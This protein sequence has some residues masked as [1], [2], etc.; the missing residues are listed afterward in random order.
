MRAKAGYAKGGRTDAAN[1]DKGTVLTLRA[2]KADIDA[3]AGGKLDAEGFKA[4]V[5]TT[6]YAGSGT[7]TTSINSWIQESTGRTRQ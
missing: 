2:R 6:A 3:F 1:A 7:G 4:K 5:T